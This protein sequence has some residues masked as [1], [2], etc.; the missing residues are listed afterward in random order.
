M[1]VLLD[2]NVLIAYL[3]PAHVHHRVA[4]SWLESLGEPFALCPITEG[5]LLRFALREGVSANDAATLLAGVHADSRSEFWPDSLSFGA[6]RL[7]G[8]IGHRQVTDAYLA[9]LARDHDA[10]LATFDKGV[11]ALHADVAWLMKPS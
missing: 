4:E 5:A 2:A 1:S 8:V 11:A 9:Q 10:R 3:A 6:V 7:A